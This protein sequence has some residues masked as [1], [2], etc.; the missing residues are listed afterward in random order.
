[1]NIKKSLDLFLKT[2]HIGSTLKVKP[3]IKY[4]FLN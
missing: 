4:N 1:M 3:K 2:Y